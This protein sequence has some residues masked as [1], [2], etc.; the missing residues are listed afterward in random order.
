MPLDSTHRNVE[1]QRRSRAINQRG[2]AEHVEAN[3]TDVAF[4]TSGQEVTIS[5]TNPYTGSPIPDGFRFIIVS[6][7]RRAQIRKGSTDWTGSNVYFVSTE[8]GVR[9]DIR[10][11]FKFG[12]N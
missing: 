11:S 10:L 9:A 7:D 3:L 4:A 6:G 8:S 5:Y 1:D 12:G 2:L